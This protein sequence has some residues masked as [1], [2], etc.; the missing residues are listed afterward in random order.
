MDTSLKVEMWPSSPETEPRSVP[1]TSKID[2]KVDQTTQQYN[3]LPSNQD[4]G[5]NGS[6]FIILD[7]ISEEEKIEIIKLGFQS[8]QEGK[9]SLKK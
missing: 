8:Y 2:F 1:E 6:N 9:I 4:K 7:K 3:H 5:L